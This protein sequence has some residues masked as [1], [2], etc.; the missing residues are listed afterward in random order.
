[1]TSFAERLKELRN[2][3]NLTQEQLAGK[4][5]VQRMTVIRW[6]RGGNLP[7]DENLLL[8]SQIFNVTTL[9]LLGA[10]DDRNLI[11]TEDYEKLIERQREE[12]EYKL[13]T[14]YRMLNP[15]MKELVY[16]VVNNALNI[17]RKKEEKEM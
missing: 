13:L 4:L 17:Q 16:A 12:D 8:M 14:R 15:E 2:E 7:T 1:M 11:E 9:Y 5:D 3:A 6:E 10:T